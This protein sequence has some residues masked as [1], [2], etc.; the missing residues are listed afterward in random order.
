MNQK[1]RT[2]WIF[3]LLLFFSACNNA[4]EE[5][6][7]SILASSPI[8]IDKNIEEDK[9][10]LSEI[11]PYKLELENKMSSV[12]NYSMQALPKTRGEKESALGN[13]ITD[14]SLL[15]GDSLLK[16]IGEQGASGCLLNFG[17]LRTSLPLGP[18][19][20]GKIY[21]VMPFDNELYAIK[22]SNEGIEAM[23]NYLKKGAQPIAGFKVK[24]N[25]IFWLNQK[26][27]PEGSAWIITSSYLANGGDNMSFFKDYGLET[28]N[29]QLLL[30][31]A[32]I[33]NFEYLAK[34][35]LPIIANID[36]RF[37]L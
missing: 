4:T 19:T 16:N 22:L 8:K 20:L 35:E 21:E 29:L 2:Q 1:I 36:G 23:L 12:V 3:G 37:D 31:D 28:V 13:L 26:P 10:L 15:A 11:E 30:R 33:K 6:N 24:N 18:I 27:L 17:G 9:V 5:V 7:V 32:I 14:L 25:K 34:N